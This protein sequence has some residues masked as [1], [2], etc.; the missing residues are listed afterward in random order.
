[1][2]VDDLRRLPIKGVDDH[3][4]PSTFPYKGCRR[5]SMTLHNSVILLPLLPLPCLVFVALVASVLLVGRALLL[6]LATQ[7]SHF[8]SHTQV[9]QP[10]RTPARDLRLSL[11]APVCLGSLRLPSLSEASLEA[12]C[13]SSSPSAS[14]E[15]LLLRTLALLG[16]VLLPFLLVGA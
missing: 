3:R 5:L 7:V 2:T 15:A 14:L 1:M 16:L 9:S 8:P 4:R 12:L 6:L 11:F 10:T 13:T